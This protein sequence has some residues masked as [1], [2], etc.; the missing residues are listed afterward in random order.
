[1]ELYWKLFLIACFLGAFCLVVELCAKNE[2]QDSSAD[3]IYSLQKD[4]S[5]ASEYFFIIVS[6]VTE[7]TA[8]VIGFVFY[9]ASKSKAGL[10]CIYVTF[11][12]T[13]LGDVLKMAIAHP[14]PFWFDSRIDAI[15]CSKDFGSPSGHAG[16]V[17]GLIIFI[18]WINIQ[19]NL[20]V[21][22]SIA[23]VSLGLLALDRN[24][25]GLHFYFQV[26]LGY[27]I[28][29]FIVS[30]VM[31]PKFWS[32][33]ESASKDFKKTLIFQSILALLLTLGILIYFVRDPEILGKWKDNYKDECNE[34]LYKEKALFSSLLESSCL[35]IVA[36]I[37]FG[38]FL[39]KFEVVRNWKYIIASLVGLVIGG[40]IEQICEK[41]SKTLSEPAGFSLF[42]VFRFLIGVYIT[43]FI[44]YVLSFCFNNIIFYFI[45]NFMM[46]N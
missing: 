11:F 18:Y 43:A 19:R 16:T 37:N 10:L 32:F 15:L 3:Y 6:E 25:L 35:M 12:V 21:T 26:V 46:V 41:Y 36:G 22:T 7:Y 38:S 45:I 20:I 29:F 30:F 17:G 14:R 1:M 9:L 2:L 8:M 28:G 33:L 5:K 39:N 34:G 24:Y 13:W 42:C 44:P 31:L 4:R 40:V 23:T 27:S